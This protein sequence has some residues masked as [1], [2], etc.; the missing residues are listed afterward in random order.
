[1][2]DQWERVPQCTAMT[3]QGRTCSRK[4]TTQRQSRPTC[5]GHARMWDEWNESKVKDFPYTMA[6][7]RW[8]W[9]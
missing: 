4:A 9:E 2:G 8:G 3:D 1:M 7:R 5:A 6:R